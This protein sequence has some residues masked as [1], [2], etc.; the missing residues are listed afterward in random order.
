MLLLDQ[1]SRSGRCCLDVTPFLRRA[2]SWRGSIPKIGQL[3][4]TIGEQLDT[5]GELSDF[6]VSWFPLVNFFIFLVNGILCSDCLQH[7]EPRT[8]YG[9]SLGSKFILRVCCS[10]LQ[11][12]AWERDLGPLGAV[13]CWF[14][15]AS[16]WQISATCWVK[17]VKLQ[18][19]IFVSQ[20]TLR[21]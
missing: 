6:Q 14:S 15:M 17:W 21:P 13:G 20:K 18:R 8:A 5:N 1:A 12:S 3:I 9:W 4:A 11:C 19:P 7:M 2:L 16:P 10:M